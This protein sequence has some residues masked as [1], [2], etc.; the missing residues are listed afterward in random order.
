MPRTGVPQLSTFPAAFPTFPA[1]GEATLHR[2]EAMQYPLDS[3][4]VVSGRTWSPGHARPPAVANDRLDPVTKREWIGGPGGAV[5]SAG[6]GAPGA[7]RP[8]ADTATIP[9]SSSTPRYSPQARVP[10]QDTSPTSPPSRKNA[11]PLEAPASR[12]RRNRSGSPT[13]PPKAAP[14][15][16]SEDVGTMDVE[17]IRQQL[18][19]GLG[20]VLQAARPHLAALHG[21]PSSAKRLWRPVG[22]CGGVTPEEK[23]RS[24]RSRAIQ[25]PSS[26]RFPAL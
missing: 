11:A 9:G 1:A 19:P 6:A 13:P 23:T 12:R 15:L 22:Q 16:T 14:Q 3:A 5:S 7:P 4:A 10:D 20:T 8:L 18:K 25:H 26:H 21:R 17:R 2:P 24:Q